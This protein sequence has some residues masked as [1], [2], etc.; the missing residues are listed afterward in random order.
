VLFK[1]KDVV[2]QCCLN[3]VFVCAYCIYVQGEIEQHAN[4]DG[5]VGRF[6]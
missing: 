2:Q 4:S 1:R 6:D 3:M 5:K